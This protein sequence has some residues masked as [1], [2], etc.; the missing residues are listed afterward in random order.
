MSVDFFISNI[1]NIIQSNHSNNDKYQQI[2]KFVDMSSKHDDNNE[3]VCTFN[4]NG[5][6]V[7]KINKNESELIFTYNEDGNL[8]CSTNI[9]NKIENKTQDKSENKTQDK[10]E[11]IKQNKA[12]KLSDILS[13]N[14]K[15]DYKLPTGKI[16][17][18]K[19]PKDF[20]KNILK[21]CRKIIKAT[22][23][24][25][26]II[27]ISDLAFDWINIIKYGEKLLKLHNLVNIIALRCHLHDVDSAKKFVQT[28]KYYKKLIWIDPKHLSKNKW[29][30]LFDKEIDWYEYKNIHLNFIREYSDICLQNTYNNPNIKLVTYESLVQLLL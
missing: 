28:N 5:E 16:T 29:E 10:S 19:I 23:D 9:D 12:I 6:E 20:P 11:N 24:T 14:Y 1:K 15:F 2:L 26:Y 22:P 18:I 27:N 17:C 3:Q 30:S 7:C 4:E 21:K 25:K 8:I 13:K